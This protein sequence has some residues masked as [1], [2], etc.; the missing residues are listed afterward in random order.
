MS[1][2][3]LAAVGVE[4]GIPRAQRRCR[5]IDGKLHKRDEGL[6]IILPLRDEGAEHVGDYSVDAFDLG[7]IMMVWRPKDQGST[8]LRYHERLEHERLENL[9][10]PGRCSAI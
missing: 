9:F 3:M 5:I 7:I 8:S 6:P 10:N 4:W 2:W 1:A